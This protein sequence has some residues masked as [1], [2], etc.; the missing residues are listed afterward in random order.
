[1]NHNHHSNSHRKS[2]HDAM[3][4]TKENYFHQFPPIKT[5]HLRIDFYKQ[6]L[7]PD[8]LP[9]TDKQKHIMNVIDTNIKREAGEL[10]L[11]QDKD[12]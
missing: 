10:C 2:T 7:N 1:M 8:S 5:N 11:D 12:C 9:P 4:G 3:I 6:F